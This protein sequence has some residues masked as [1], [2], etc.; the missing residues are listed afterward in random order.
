MELYH[1]IRPDAYVLILNGSVDGDNAIE[2]DLAFQK[3][4]QS[5]RG[6]VLVS[7]HN[8]TFISAAGIK[9]FSAHLPLFREKGVHLVFEGLPARIRSAF[10]LWGLELPPA[11]AE[12]R[13]PNPKPAAE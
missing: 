2:L 5:K 12:A 8:L 11:L 4:L 10:Q 7:C 6:Q 9:L 1:E 13:L 3:A